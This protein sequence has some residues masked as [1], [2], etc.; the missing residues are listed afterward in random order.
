METKRETN[1]QADH[2]EP[3]R[4]NNGRADGL[5]REREKDTSEKGRSGLHRSAVKSNVLNIDLKGPHPSLPYDGGNGMELA[6]AK[7]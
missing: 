5:S 1:R 3:V 4:C 7:I 6:S 2:R